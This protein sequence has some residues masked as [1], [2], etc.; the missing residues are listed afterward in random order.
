MS[1]KA[2]LMMVAALT[3]AGL[4]TAVVASPVGTPTSSPDSQAERVSLAGLDLHSERGASLALSRIRQAAKDV[5]GVPVDI[6]P[7]WA[8]ARPNTCVITV[9]D[10][11]V[12]KLDDP[13]VSALNSGH[14]G[15]GAQ[16]AAGRR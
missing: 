1:T 11:A 8:S 16:L 12:T 14:G 13:M 10:R 7:I 4:A 3:T 15:S 9:V 6:G 2:T 5:C